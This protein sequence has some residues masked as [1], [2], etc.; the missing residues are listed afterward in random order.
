[1]TFEKKVQGIRE[2]AGK[3]KNSIDK[4]VDDYSRLGEKYSFLRNKVES[5][6]DRSYREIMD[7]RYHPE[8]VERRLEKAEPWLRPSILR[9]T[10]QVYDTFLKKQ[11]LLIGG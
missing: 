3:W 4:M 9:K 11:N 1:M 2:G 8:V 6:F 7:K 5:E 10:I